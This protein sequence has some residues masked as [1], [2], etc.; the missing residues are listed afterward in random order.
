MI[1]KRD[2]C[3][4]LVKH[5]NLMNLWSIDEIIPDEN[6]F[7]TIMKHFN[8]EIVNKSIMYSYF[9]TRRSP[10]PK[11]YDTI[12]NIDNKEIRD[13]HLFFR[14]I[15]KNFQTANILEYNC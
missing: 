5:E 1:L 11:T 8:F 13:K 4:F 6:Y 14:K 2:V 7:I 10:H 15:S 3:E 12:N 9:E